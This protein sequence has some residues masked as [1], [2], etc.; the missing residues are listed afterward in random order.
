MVWFNV[1][2]YTLEVISE[3]KWAMCT[4]EANSDL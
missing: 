1:P 2:L 4:S 3:T